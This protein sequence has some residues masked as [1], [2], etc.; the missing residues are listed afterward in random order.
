MKKE[1]P[2]CTWRCG[3][4]VSGNGH[5]YDISFYDSL[6]TTSTSAGG[7]AVE[8]FPRKFMRPFPPRFDDD[9]FSDWVPGDTAEMFDSMS[10]KAV[11]VSDLLGADVYLVRLLGSLQEVRAHKSSLRVQQIWIRDEW[12]MLGRH[13][14]RGNVQGLRGKRK[15][16]QEED[17]SDTESVGSNDGINNSNQ[18]TFVSIFDSGDAE[19]RFGWGYSYDTESPLPS[20]E[21]IAV[22]LTC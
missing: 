22:G 11:S 18:T 2:C 6:G 9:A 10:W 15:L 5:N 17:L 20:K 8:R 14:F 12:V 1:L 21:V 4:I 13:K 3:E 7:V 16:C 19:S